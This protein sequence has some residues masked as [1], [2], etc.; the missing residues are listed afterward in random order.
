MRGMRTRPFLD[1]A[2]RVRSFVDR[3][4]RIRPFVNVFIIFWWMRYYMLRLCIILLL[5]LTGYQVLCRA[6]LWLSSCFTMLMFTMLLMLYIFF[7]YMWILFSCLLDLILSQ[8]QDHG[9]EVTIWGRLVGALT[10][11]DY[12]ILEV[13]KSSGGRL[14]IEAQSSWRYNC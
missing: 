1:R 9:R 5:R 4:I 13:Y 6:H 14:V 11:V 10:P 12:N 3:G 2:L 7:L 8:P